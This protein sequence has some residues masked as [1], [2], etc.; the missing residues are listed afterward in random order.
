LS[1]KHAVIK[2]KKGVHYI[3]DLGSTNGTLLNGQRLE[4]T[5]TALRDGDRIHA[6]K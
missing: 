2:E 4:Q 1:G 3:T 6:L 5:E